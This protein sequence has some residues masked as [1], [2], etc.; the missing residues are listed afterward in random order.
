[1]KTFR[2]SSFLAFLTLMG[3]WVLSFR[4]SLVL[5][6][7]EPVYLSPAANAILNSPP[8]EVRIVFSEKILAATTIKVL[9]SNKQQVDV[10]NG[11]ID[12]NDARSQTYVLGLPVLENGVYTVEWRSLAA[13]GHT[14]SGK[15]SFTLKLAPTALPPTSAPPPPTAAPIS[16]AP[17][18]NAPSVTALPS[19]VPALATPSPMPTVTVLPTSAVTPAPAPRRE[20]SPTP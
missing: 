1:M 7:A 13:D 11:K 2:Q 15:F 16:P 18:T 4:P 5:A 12:P 6:H 20:A 14:E 3:L 9:N 10:K 19:A 8:T 17:T